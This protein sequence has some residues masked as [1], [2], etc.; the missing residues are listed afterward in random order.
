MPSRAAAGE[1]VDLGGLLGDMHGVVQ[2]EHHDA[3]AQPQPL[4][5]GGEVGEHGE[6]VRRDA[7]VTEVVLGQPYAVEAQFLGQFGELQ[8]VVVD[9][10]ELWPSNRWKRWKVENFIGS[11]SGTSARLG[12]RITADET[13]ARAGGRERRKRVPS[14]SGSGRTLRP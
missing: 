13:A 9:L 14:F 7:V 12:E 11:S 8:M 2:G 10:L 5:A 6:E 1:Q 4:G 3:G